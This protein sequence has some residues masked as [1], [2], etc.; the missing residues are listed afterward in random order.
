MYILNFLNVLLS[1]ND[2]IICYCSITHIDQRLCSITKASNEKWN[3]LFE[4]SLRKLG[5]KHTQ[6]SENT[7][8]IWNYWHLVSSQS[9]TISPS[10]LDKQSKIKNFPLKRSNS[11][12]GRF[13]HHVDKYNTMS[14]LH[15]TFPFSAEPK[16]SNGEHLHSLMK[17]Y[18]EKVRIMCVRVSVLIYVRAWVCV[19][20][21]VCV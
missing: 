18:L 9:K 21:C 20:V 6:H 16:K 15:E 5:L 14:S 13:K 8:S 3:S 19:P 1:N 2:T 11:L 12:P 17:E 10:M 7:L 4:R